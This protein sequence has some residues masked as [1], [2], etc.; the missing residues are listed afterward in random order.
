MLFLAVAKLP[1][2]QS[3]RQSA[4]PW[5]TRVQTSELSKKES[6]DW[7]EI[8]LE[9]TTETKNN[10]SILHLNYHILKSLPIQHWT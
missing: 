4:V 6:F 7:L 9:L 5:N 10:S 3:V 1:V 2:L 8:T